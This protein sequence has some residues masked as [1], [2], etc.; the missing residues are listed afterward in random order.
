M[1]DRLWLVFY[2]PTFS[3]STPFLWVSILNLQRVA[4]LADKFAGK[5]E[6]G[7]LDSIWIMND[8]D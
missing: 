2:H 4:N 8:R 3:N 1:N 5:T 6:R 7:K